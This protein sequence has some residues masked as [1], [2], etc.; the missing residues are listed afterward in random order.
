[1]SNPSLAD[2]AKKGFVFGESKGWLTDV[3]LAQDAAVTTL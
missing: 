3:K 2:V 1:M